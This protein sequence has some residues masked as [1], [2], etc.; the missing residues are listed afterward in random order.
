MNRLTAIL[1]VFFAA[2]CSQAADRITATIAVTN[3][4]LG[5]TN[6]ITINASTRTFTNSVTGSPGTLV[7]ETNSVPWTATNLINQL[8]DYR[9]SQFHFLGQSASNNVRITGTVGEALTVTLAGGWGT[10][11]YSTQNVTIANVV[12]V[13]MSVEFDTNRAWI[14]S[15]LV[16]GLSD[17]ATNG[18]ATNATALANYV[19]KGAS[20]LQTISAPLQVSGTLGVSV[21]S[22]TNASFYNATNRGYVVALTNGYWTNGTLGSPKFTNAV[23]Y[24]NAISSPGDG[25]S[26]EQ[27]GAGA[28]ARNDYDTA[29]GATALATNG[30]AA[31]FGYGANAF[32]GGTAIG[33]LST[34]N[35]NSAA[36]GYGAL[37]SGIE[38]VVIGPNSDDDG[39][40]NV[41]IIGD[42]INGVANNQV[43]IGG[44]SQ[45]VTIGGPIVGATTTNTTLRGTNVINGRIDYTSRANTGL[46]NGNNAGVVLGTNVFLRLSGPT[47]NYTLNGFAAE[48]DGSFHI[49]EL[50][51]PTSSITV[52]N[53]SGTDPT[54]AN[55]ITTGT[56]ADVTITNNP[57][58]L[59][60]I[61]NTT[62]SR[63]RV[64]SYSR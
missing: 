48:Q 26:S 14:A 27:F 16:T 31:A 42:S 21:A 59:Q 54:A 10:V 20:A 49:L 2:F 30:S 57:A 24:G 64:I 61:Y 62:A 33:S 45:T 37:A 32:S 12:R 4:P 28:H 46:A 51:N 13:P 1:F 56:G 63:W 8:T 17:Y 23:N 60:V 47:G 41:I 52:A 38:N 9:V 35:T 55:R 43:I 40:A 18:F 34:A 58:F 36:V 53:N 39:Y 44:T 50:D 22:I 6:S 7:Q 19:S 25:T 11:T 15:L 5:N 3:A 29:F